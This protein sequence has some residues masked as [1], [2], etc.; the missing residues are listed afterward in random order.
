MY[1]SWWRTHIIFSLGGFENHWTERSD[2]SQTNQQA[3]ND[4]PNLFLLA[5]E[6]LKTELKKLTTSIS[7]TP[8]LY[9]SMSFQSSH[10]QAPRGYVTFFIGQITNKIMNKSKYHRQTKMTLTLPL[11]CGQKS[12]A[13]KFLKASPKTFISL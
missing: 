1:V 13:V 12:W 4:R 2:N 11:A 10:R 7:P 9:N 5:L 3:N 6:L 8:H